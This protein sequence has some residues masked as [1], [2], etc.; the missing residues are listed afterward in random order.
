MRRVPPTASCCG[1]P[2]G[3]DCTPHSPL[4]ASSNGLRLSGARPTPPSDDVSP[5]TVCSSRA[6]RVRCSRG[7]DAMRKDTAVAFSRIEEER[8]EAYVTDGVP[9]GFYRGGES[10]SGVLGGWV[11]EVAAGVWL[12]DGPEAVA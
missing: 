7:L 5:R 4:R 12:G 2:D 9:K 10:A 11:E 6:A 8:R 1:A 3:D